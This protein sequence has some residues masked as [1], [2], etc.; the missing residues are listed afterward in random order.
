MYK[1]AGHTFDIIV[2][3]G[4]YSRDFLSQYAPFEEAD[5]GR[6]PLFSLEL[7]FCDDLDAVSGDLKER[8]NEEAP[9]FW[10]F[11]KNGCYRFGFSLSTKRTACVVVHSPESGQNT[12]YVPSGASERHSLFALNNAMMLLFTL[13]TTPFDTLMIHASVTCH[14]GRAFVFLGRSGTGK[15]THSRLWLENIPDTFLLNDDNPAIRLVDGIPVVFGTPWS[16]KTPCYKNDSRPMGAFVR[17]EQAPQNL[18]SRLSPL[19]AYAAL[20]PSCSCMRWEENACESLHSTVEKVIMSVPGFHLQCLP[21]SAAAWM[22]H[23]AALAV[24]DDMK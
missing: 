20:M 4:V 17:L 1:V 7:A 8:Y 15:S 6:K 3:S 22:S 21:D 18:I 9:Y 13:Y 14:Q 12:V 16:G 2:P 11:E 10:L 19:Q 24:L 23:D 5:S